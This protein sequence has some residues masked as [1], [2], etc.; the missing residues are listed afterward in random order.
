MYR[1]KKRLVSDTWDIEA[2]SLFE[3]KNGKLILVDDDEYIAFDYEKHKEKF[4]PA[5]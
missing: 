3:L 1:N 4:E 5:T 2:G